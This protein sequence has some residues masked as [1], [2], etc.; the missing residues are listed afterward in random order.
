M[1]VCRHGQPMISLSNI[2]QLNQ[3]IYIFDKFFNSLFCRFWGMSSTSSPFAILPSFSRCLWM[4]RATW[5]GGKS[6]TNSYFAIFQSSSRWL[7]MNRLTW[8]WGLS[9]TN[10]LFTIFLSFSRWLCINMLTCSWGLSFTN[11]PFTIFPSSSSNRSLWMYRRPWF[12]HAYRR[13]LY[14]L[15]CLYS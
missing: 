12:N 7:W 11:S 4:Y 2:A 13:K 8:S 1:S 3:S 15:P 14:F 10:S 6:S 9:F 5:F